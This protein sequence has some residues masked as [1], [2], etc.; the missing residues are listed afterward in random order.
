M[1]IE[2]LQDISKLLVDGFEDW[3]GYGRIYT[4]TKGDLTI[5]NYRQTAI[6]DGRWPFLE[7]VSRGL[8]INNKTGGIVA[9]PF[10]KFFN[11]GEGSW[12]NGGRTTT[13]DISF[14]TEKYDGSLGILYYDAPVDSD[15]STPRIATRGSFDGDQAVWA[16]E[17]F[18]ERWK[19]FPQTDWTL[20]FEIIYPE[21]R[22][23]V[24]YGDTE[25]LILL[26]ARSIGSGRYM[27]YHELR[28]MADRLGFN[29]VPF[30]AHNVRT[31]IEEQKRIDYNQEGWV[32][33]FEDG[34]IF[35]FKG[36]QYMELHKSIMGLTWKNTVKA[37][38]DGQEDAIRA[39]IPEEFLGEFNTWVD[40]ITRKAAR[41]LDQVYKALYHKPHKATRKEYA[42]W[43]QRDYPELEHYLYAVRDGHDF[44]SM[45]L[46]REF[47]EAPDV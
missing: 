8:I 21:N 20:M 5:F 7:R 10:D 25:D 27:P 18:Q 19:H 16:T 22:V 30:Y 42:L 26:A 45:I 15:Y 29:L 3:G 2:S 6:F 11:W 4:V 32:A 33:Y 31:L 14:V 9:R 39:I 24:D 36:E 43:A 38:R 41:R 47:K 28:E 13:A 37:V 17:F 34:S 23:V 46:D 40:Y 1:K 35:K 12:R 44:E